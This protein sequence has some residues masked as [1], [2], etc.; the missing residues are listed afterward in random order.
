MSRELKNWGMLLLLALVWGSSFILMKRGMIHKDTGDAIFN[1][2]QVAALRMLIA[3]AFLLPLGLRHFAE[4]KKIKLVL[5]LGVVAFVG[6]FFP[7]FLFT[8]A[9][10]GISSGFAGMLN[11]CTPIF[12]LLLGT[13][14]F[15]QKL[16]QLQV[17]GVIVGTIGIIWLVNS[18]SVV[19][20][21]GSWLHVMAVVL[22]TLFYAMSVNVIRYNLVGINPLKITTMAF[23]LSFIPALI[24]F[25]TL[26]IP[27]T[28]RTTPYLWEGLIP[29]IIL[30][31]IGTAISVIIFN[32]LIAKSSA[33]F[34]SSVTYFIPIVAVLIG[35][36]DGEQLSIIQILAMLVILSGVYVA[37][38]I[39]RRKRMKVESNKVES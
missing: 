4:F 13:W 7:A 17:I 8:Y 38:V 28:I 2:N 12:T 20:T 22:A 31:L 35:L 5:N 25:F 10:T 37:N 14:F 18:V 9:E 21:S 19:D 33:L 15:R 11:S 29:I 39:G 3:S 36:W 30:S 34:A 23:S 1:S 26:D 32:E 6:N 27:A 24:L 16:I